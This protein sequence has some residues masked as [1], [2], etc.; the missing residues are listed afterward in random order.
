MVTKSMSELSY[1][2]K[3]TFQSAENQHNISQAQ[4]ACAQ[5][6]LDTS[7]TMG[8][9]INAFV[10]KFDLD[11]VDDRYAPYHD[12][13]HIIAMACD[14]SPHSEAITGVTEFTLLRE[15]YNGNENTVKERGLGA[16]LSV[17][18]QFNGSRAQ[19]FEEA[20]PLPAYQ[21]AESLGKERFEATLKL[22]SIKRENTKE[23]THEEL[24]NAYE[25]AK[26]VDAFFQTLMGERTIYQLSTQELLDTPLCFF[27]VEPKGTLKNTSFKAI[28]EDTKDRVIEH[29]GGKSR[30][31]FAAQFART[32]AELH[33]LYPKSPN[34]HLADSHRSSFDAE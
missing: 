26:K 18:H 28:S 8:D 32:E 33:K 27:G 22:S 29:L 30:P 20:A 11:T 5:A 31:L 17:C 2:A 14:P 15:P 23:V 19:E 24:K 1:I 34:L 3:L 6:G 21:S 7:I 9:A 4:S 16:M 13:M 10:E 25:H 12:A